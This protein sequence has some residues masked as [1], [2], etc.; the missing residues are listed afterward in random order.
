MAGLGPR[1]LDLSWLLFA[2][3]VFEHLASRF[4][5]PGMPDF[6]RADGVAAHYERATGH[7]VG[8][9]GFYRVYAALQWGVVFLRTGV[10]SVHFGE[11]EMPDDPEEFMHHRELFE[12]VLG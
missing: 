8:D 5:A 2:H 7:T 6:L 4:G 12:H 1:E 3:E 11:R 9:L 10:R